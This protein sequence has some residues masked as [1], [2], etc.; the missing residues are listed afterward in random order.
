[1]L[2]IPRALRRMQLKQGGASRERRVRRVGLM[3]DILEAMGFD[4]YGTAIFSTRNSAPR[5]RAVRDRLR[6]IGRLTVLTKQLDMAL[7]GDALTRWYT[8]DIAKKL[9]LDPRICT[10]NPAAERRR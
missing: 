4:N 3:A 10:G 8:E 2:E 5:R 1:V 7:S 6:S 9:G